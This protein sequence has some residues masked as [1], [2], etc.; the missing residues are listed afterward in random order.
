LTEQYEQ[1]KG[2]YE[3][4]NIDSTDLT[5][6]YEENKSKIYQNETQKRIG[7]AEHFI[8]VASN[9]T[10]GLQTLNDAMTARQLRNLDKQHLSEKEYAKRKAAIEEESLEKRRQFA[11]AEQLIIIAQTISN[12][13]KGVASSLTGPPFI[14]WVDVAATIAAGAIQIATI[15]AQNFANGRGLVDMLSNGRNADTI[16]AR[17]GKGEYI[18]PADKT[19]QNIDDLEAMRKGVGT[20]A[21]GQVITQNFYSVPLETMIQVQRDMQRKNLASQ[22]I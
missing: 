18:M 20:R 19:A 12:V 16:N 9:L 5:K 8:N 17:I 13:A 15:E 1:E 22:R 21:G 2:L 11:R 7:Y 14:K 10:N 6:I 3:T 4:Y